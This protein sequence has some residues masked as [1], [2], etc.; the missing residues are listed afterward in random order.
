[1]AGPPSETSGLFTIFE[2][3]NT[4]RVLFHL[5][6]STIPIRH[7]IANR[8]FLYLWHIFVGIFVAEPIIWAR[9]S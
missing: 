9:K 4:N 7:V 3:N 6:M 5:E 2:S 8:R 1:M